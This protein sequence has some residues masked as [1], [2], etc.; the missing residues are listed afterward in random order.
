MRTNL[1]WTIIAICLLN[2]LLNWLAVVVQTLYSLYTY[3]RKKLTTVFR[4]F[5]KPEPLDFK[6]LELG[7][8]E[9][10]ENAMKYGS[11]R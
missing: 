9:E 6:K 8:L 5:A 3:L 7:D 1:G 11:R 4:K 2:I 10:M